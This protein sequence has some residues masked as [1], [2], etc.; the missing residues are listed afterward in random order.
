MRGELKSY[1]EEGLAELKQTNEFNNDYLM[2]MWSEF[3]VSKPTF[4]WERIWPLVV[5]GHWI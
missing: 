3:L 1:C 4:T 2:N 5:L